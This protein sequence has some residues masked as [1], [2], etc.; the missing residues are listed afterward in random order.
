MEEATVQLGRNRLA[1]FK[2]RGGRLWLL[3]VVAASA[4]SDHRW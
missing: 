4:S 1:Q 2:N 3:G